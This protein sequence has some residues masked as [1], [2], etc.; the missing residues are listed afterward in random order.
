MIK[1][2]KEKIIGVRVNEDLLIIL[3]SFKQVKGY[4]Y[5]ETIRNA[6]EYYCTCA[7]E[8]ESCVKQIT[9]SACDTIGVEQ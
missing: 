6:L 7:I 2:N 3:N 8:K 5:S 4:S 1:Q 9:N